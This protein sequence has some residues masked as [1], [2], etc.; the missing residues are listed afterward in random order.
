VF[1][2]E[3]ARQQVRNSDLDARKQEFQS[4]RNT[5]KQKGDR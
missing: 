1:A 5:F 3:S 2:S 4:R